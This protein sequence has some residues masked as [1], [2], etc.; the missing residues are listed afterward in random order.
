MDEPLLITGLDAQW[1][2]SSEFSKAASHFAGIFAKSK[3]RDTDGRAEYKLTDLA[4]QQMDEIRKRICLEDSVLKLTKAGDQLL[5]PKTF[6]IVRD[7]AQVNVERGRAITLR[8]FRSGTRQ[9]FCADTGKVK[10][11]MESNGL[12]S[13]VITPKASCTLVFFIGFVLRWY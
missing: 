5:S 1:A 6:G 8:L 11:F 10:S 9:I 7:K 13:G 12:A 3:L 2:D 4:V